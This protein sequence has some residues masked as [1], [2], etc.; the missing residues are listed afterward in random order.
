MYD[1]CGV[2]L[3]DKA[4]YNTENGPLVVEC[5]YYDGN[6]WWANAEYIKRLDPKF[7]YRSDTPWLRGKS[8]LWIGSG[9]PRAANLFTLEGE[10]P[11]FIDYTPANYNY[12]F[13]QI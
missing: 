12:A 11:Y 4:T 9:E 13:K 10:N 2:Q 3:S 1:T 7:L 8:E 5:T 6:F